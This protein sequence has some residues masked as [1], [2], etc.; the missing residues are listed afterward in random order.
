MSF[1]LIVLT[2][3][4]AVNPARLRPS[5]PED[6]VSRQARA[7]ELGLGSLLVFAL[8][9]V[10]AG[11]AV[12]LLDS[13][14][15]SPESFRIAAGLVMALVGAWVI[16]FPTRGEE[17]ELSGWGAVLVPI[18]FP[19]LITPELTVLVL[20]TGADEP[21]GYMLGALAIA[22]LTANLVGQVPG[23]QAATAVWSGISRLLGAFLVVAGIE[24]VID[25]IRDV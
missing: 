21:T 19:L 2:Y 11:A 17:P 1:A 14:R 23:S 13:L 12:S 24:F 25:G 8:A 16:I 4:A 3:L 15:I 20:S 10:G 6:A 5:L 7:A 9:W 22:L 18:A